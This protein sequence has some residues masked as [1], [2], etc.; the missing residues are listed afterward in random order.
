MIPQEVADIIAILYDWLGPD[1]DDNEAHMIANE[2]YRKV[3]HPINK[4]EC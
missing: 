4:C 3:I 2:I 1:L